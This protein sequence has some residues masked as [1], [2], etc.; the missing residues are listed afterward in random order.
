MEPNK[1]YMEK[2]NIIIVDDEMPDRNAISEILSTIEKIKLLEICS[3]EEELFDY[4]KNEANPM[5]HIILLDMMFGKNATRG[6]EI[7]KIL[8]DSFIE[9][10]PKTYQFRIIVYS[11]G[12]GYSADKEIFGKNI[13]VIAKAIEEGATGFIDKGNIKNLKNELEDFISSRQRRDKYFFNNSILQTIVE[14]FLRYSKLSS[15]ET[16]EKSIDNE[17]TKEQAFK[18]LKLD[19]KIDGETLKLIAEGHTNLFIAHKMEWKGEA[20]LNE[21]KVENDREKLSKT[22]NVANKATAITIKALQKGLIDLKEI[23]PIT[24]EQQTDEN[25]SLKKLKKETKSEEPEE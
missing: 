1:D 15:K 8:R 3:D 6:I 20:G 11:S 25:S 2:Y 13:D 21:K 7:I 10:A 12:Y 9:K 22:L 5:P 24:A 4:L 23:N 19:A 16:T 17:Q 18:D 14:G